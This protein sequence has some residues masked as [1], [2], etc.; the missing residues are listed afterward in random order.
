MKRQRPK[1]IIALHSLAAA[2][3]LCILTPLIINLNGW[4]IRYDTPINKAEDR[5]LGIG[6]G[7]FHSSRIPHYPD[8]D[9]IDSEAFGELFEIKTIYK[10][11]RK[12]LYLEKIHSSISWNLLHRSPADSLEF[13]WLLT[14]TLPAALSIISLAYASRE[15]TSE[16]STAEQREQTNR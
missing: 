7:L 15:P 4:A 3:F 16:S 10:S 5:H 2:L 14:L 6:T 8:S 11:N 9:F 12:H 1:I 13:N